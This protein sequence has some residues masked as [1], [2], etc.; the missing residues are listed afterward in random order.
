MHDGEQEISILLNVLSTDHRMYRKCKIQITTVPILLYL[1]WGNLSAGDF[2]NLTCLV[3][4]I[5]R[6][7]IC[8]F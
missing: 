2:L 3:P 7:F 6:Y 1:F 4:Y 8:N 5:Y